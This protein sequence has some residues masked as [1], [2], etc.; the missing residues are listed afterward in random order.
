MLTNSY[1]N[2]A[3][4]LFMLFLMLPILL[5]PPPSTYKTIKQTKTLQDFP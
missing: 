1:N 4:L 5:S 2:I 3:L